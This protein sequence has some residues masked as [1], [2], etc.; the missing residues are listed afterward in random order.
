MFGVRCIREGFR[1]HCSFAYGYFSEQRQIRIDEQNW[2][3]FPGPNSDIRLGDVV[4]S[5]LTAGFGGVI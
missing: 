2:R 4:V 1:F 5:K 3:R